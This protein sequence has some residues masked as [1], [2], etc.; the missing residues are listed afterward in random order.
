LDPQTFRLL[1][2]SNNHS[3][4]SGHN[5]HDCEND[6][7]QVRHG[8]VF[9]VV[10]HFGFRVGSSL[11]TAAGDKRIPIILGLLKIPTWSEM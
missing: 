11:V 7:P 9:E 2:Q 1:K 8:D 10:L 3:H 4:G 6:I 5:R